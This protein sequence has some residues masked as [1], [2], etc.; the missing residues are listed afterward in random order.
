MKNGNQQG[1]AV[2]YLNSISE[3]TGLKFKFEK[4]GKWEDVIE[5]FKYGEFQLLHSANRDAER[6]QYGLFS[7]PYLT[8]PI[9][10]FGRV[11]SPRINS[12]ED[13]KN[14]KIGVVSS[15]TITKNYKEFYPDLNY[16]EYDKITDALRGLA[17]SE[18]DVLTGN[19]VFLNYVINENFIPGL[20]VIGQNYLKEMENARHY[21]GVLKENKTLIDIINKAL[22]EITNTEQ[23]AISI[24]WQAKIATM[25]KMILV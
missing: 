5:S 16:V 12:I 7:P 10:N 21:F 20:E 8:M 3:K 23:Q 2:D 19:L 14:R 17:T 1:I 25:R 6:D 15:F 24:K 18:I 4:Q 11:G 13:L 9:V 22:A